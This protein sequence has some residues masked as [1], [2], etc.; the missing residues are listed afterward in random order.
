MDN[1][2][3]LIRLLNGDDIVGYVTNNLND[4]YYISG[5]MIVAVEYKGNN[6]GLIM[7]QWLPVQLVE[8]NEVLLYGKDIL[9]MT[10]V[11][12]DFYDYYVSVM[13]QLQKL[14]Q[15]EKKIAMN[16]GPENDIMNDVLEVFKD[17]EAGT[18]LLH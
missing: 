4:S 3:K 14:L 11:T 18:V 7:R 12:S 10:E 6:P 16:D 17:L 5:P 13:E 2:I 15:A 1:T 8:T 9:F